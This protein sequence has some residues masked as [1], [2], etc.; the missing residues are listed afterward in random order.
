MSTHAHSKKSSAFL[1]PLQNILG[2]EKRALQSQNAQLSAVLGSSPYEY[3]GLATDGSV[4]Y[5]NGL[6]TLLD[7]DHFSSLND[8]GDALAPDDAAALEGLYDRLKTEGRDF[9]V[10]VRTANRQ[11]ILKIIGKAGLPQSDEDQSD[12]HVLWFEDITSL[13][14]EQEQLKGTRDEIGMERD[15]LQT[16]INRIPLPIWMRDAQA[17]I[18]FCNKAYAEAV[19]STAATVISKQTELPLKP[20]HKTSHK[21]TDKALAQAALDNNKM[22]ETI[23][24]VIMGGKRHLMKICEMPLPHVNMTMGMA[25]D[26][27]R[28]EELEKGHE[29][30]VSVNNELLEQLG[31]AV[32]TF[33]AQ[34]RLEFYNTAFSR[35]WQL[36]D[37]YLN[38][39]PKLGD[40]M[41]KLRETRRL[42]EQADFRS[43][44]QSWL[45]M[46]T[47]LIEPFED[48]LYLPDAS[49]LR[50]LVVPHPM[51]GLMMTFEDVS[52]R[53]E[54]ESSYNTLIAVQKETL[55]NLAEGVA[56]Y[57]GDGRLKL[58]NPSFSKIWNLQPEDLDGEPHVSR[59][60]EKMRPY[61]ASSQW[62]GW[63]N[64]ISAQALNREENSGR[65]ERG[66]GT[67]LAYSTVPLPDGGV[68]VSY[69]D[70]SD[71]VRAE[72]ALRDKNLA[73]ETAERIKLDFL[74]NVSYQL[75]TPLN[76]IM[77][78]SEILNNEYFGKLNDKQKEY[79]GGLQEA[80][81][82]LLNLVND[83]LDLST[84]EAGYLDLK[85]ED[86]ALY[87][88]LKNLHDLT[89]EWAQKEKLKLKLNCPKNIG[90]IWA[91]EQRLKQIMLNL[92][93]NAIAFT[94]E[95]GTIDVTAVK[96]NDDWVKLTV[97]DTGAG[98]SEKDLARIFTPFERA[99]PQ[100]NTTPGSGAG[101]GLTLVKN[102]VDL[103]K[104]KVSVESAEGEGTTITVE[105]PT[106][107]LDR[108]SVLG[109]KRSG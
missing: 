39:K 13:L 26:M 91:D 81:T 34:E 19:G 77:G 44:K 78:F 12:F 43:F 42:P 27:T 102:I 70:I 75:R 21:T 58:W 79:T 100:D 4:T 10:M 23:A 109:K 98:I 93:R 67:L 61:F 104:G 17:N 74:A 71:R 9:D 38:S 66:D 68:L 108:P 28:E 92:I 82:K 101:L 1:N 22:E 33:D 88:T 32:G 31:T 54:L 14:A 96:E 97:T 7:S 49:A 106:R 73:L 64:N 41:E 24:H 51:G 86:V 80:G 29:R 89:K 3:C 83:I 16:A 50:M 48:M 35:L 87:P 95:G 46:F 84:I 30:Y 62:E 2:G 60:V 6:L 59:L 99:N 52:S 105:L 85:K 53:L 69:S 11:K 76:A 47:R 56:V 25:L 63:K 107:S 5:S 45:S 18:T 57:G 15:R 103:H 55:D 20:T 65:M 94:P 90:T 37:Q 72:N 36:D 8:V 40:L